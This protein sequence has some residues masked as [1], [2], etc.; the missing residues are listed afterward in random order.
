MSYLDGREYLTV[1]D[2]DSGTIY[3]FDLTF[4]LSSYNCTWGRGCKGMTGVEEH[5]CCIKGVTIDGPAELNRVSAAVDRLTPDL[6]ANHGKYHADMDWVEEQD[7]PDGA[8][9]NTTVLNGVCIFHNPADSEQ[10]TGCALHHLAQRE[11]GDPDHYRPDACSI[12][13]LMAMWNDDG[14]CTIGPIMRQGDNCMA[15]TG[16]NWW[17]IDDPSNYQPYQGRFYLQY[18]NTLV[19]VTSQYVVEQLHAYSEARKTLPRGYG[20]P[21]NAGEDQTKWGYYPTV[22]ITLIRKRVDQ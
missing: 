18:W 5:G 1:T 3:H 19:R 16:N 12:Y 22:P 2:P 4:M 17:C 9:H 15:D 10:P 11:G 14:S 21:A 20:R 6:W 8:S 7:D 13:P